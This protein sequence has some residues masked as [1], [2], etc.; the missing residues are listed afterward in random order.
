MTSIEIL[1]S[2][3]AELRRFFIGRFGYGWQTKVKRR[4][5]RMKNVP[6]WFLDGSKLNRYPH[7][8]LARFESLATQLG[9]RLSHLEKTPRERKPSSRRRKATV[10]LNAASGQP[11]VRPAIPSAAQSE[12]NTACHT[13]SITDS[14]QLSAP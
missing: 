7:F 6:P 8:R 4:V 12:H 13:Q 2:R 1:R 10:C 3:V 14:S 5:G 11:P 9:H